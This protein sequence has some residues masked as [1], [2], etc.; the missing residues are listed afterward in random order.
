MKLANSNP[1]PEEFPLG[2][3]E[4][5][6]AARALLE[7][8]KETTISVQIIHIGR[9]EGD[10]LPS[11]KFSGGVRIFHIAGESSTVG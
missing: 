5:R 4:S 1:R 9:L 11:P 8:R 6:A 2:S 7:A 10:S 3:I